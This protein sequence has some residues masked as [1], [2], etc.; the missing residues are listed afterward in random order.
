MKTEILIPFTLDTTPIEAKM[1]ALGEAEVAKKVSEII[2]QRVAEQLP[3]KYDGYSGKSSTDWKSYLDNRLY[4]WLN[5]HAQDIID[6]AA[7]LL[8][9]RGF[10]RK[11]WKTV[12][13]ECRELEEQAE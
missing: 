2:E 1:G 9:T 7:M 12:L 6:E 10:R 11:E 3:R 5:D 8:A 13:R 4:E